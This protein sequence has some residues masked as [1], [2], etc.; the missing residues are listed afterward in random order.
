M[1]KYANLFLDSD[2]LAGFLVNFHQNRPID[3]RRKY[4][5][6]KCLEELINM[7]ED[8]KIFQYTLKEIFDI[9][10]IHAD[11][12]FNFALVDCTRGKFIADLIYNKLNQISYGEIFKKDFNIFQDVTLMKN[13]KFLSNVL[14]NPLIKDSKAA[15][16]ENLLRMNKSEIDDILSLNPFFSYLIP[17]LMV[18]EHEKIFS[19]FVEKEKVH[20]GNFTF[21]IYQNH[22]IKNLITF[23]SLKS[24]ISVYKH[25]QNENLKNA[26]LVC[27]KKIM[28]AF[29]NKS[30]KKYP[31]NVDEFR[32][33]FDLEA[34]EFMNK[35][36]IPLGFA[37][38]RVNLGEEVV[39]NI[40]YTN[41]LSGISADKLARGV[42]IFDIIAEN[43]QHKEIKEEVFNVF[44]LN[45]SNSKI[46]IWDM[47]TGSLN[48]INYLDLVK[49]CDMDKK[50]EIIQKISAKDFFELNGKF[51]FI[52][53]IGGYGTN[54]NIEALNQRFEKY[55]Q[56]NNLNVEQMSM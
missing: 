30:G 23:G 5:T 8:E 6:E 3:N 45:Y 2:F 18:D 37:P 22:I 33:E 19:D 35:H 20:T 54:F 38:P 26:I 36:A 27:A 39:K 53:S 14:F 43:L 13:K 7:I 31:T 11:F 40:K 12:D 4:K 56:N 44:M 24:M 46:R 28:T 21:N 47:E 41:F 48:R 55:K 10:N 29:S 51:Y 52:E 17:E 49:D 9:H 1:K 32:K 25:T 42:S 50:T 15:F 34:V 16:E